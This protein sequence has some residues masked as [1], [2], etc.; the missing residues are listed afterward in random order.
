MSAV[1]WLVRKFVLEMPTA[2]SFN[3]LASVFFRDKEN[4]DDAPSSDVDLRLRTG[5]AGFTC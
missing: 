2:S 4:T 1:D 5:L 3:G